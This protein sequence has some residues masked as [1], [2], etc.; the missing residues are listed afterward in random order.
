MDLIGRSKDSLLMVE[1]VIFLK[2]MVKDSEMNTTLEIENSN[3]E[4]RSWLRKTYWL[5]KEGLFKGRKSRCLGINGK[6]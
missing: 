5:D 3:L 2:Q 4:E 6:R 1:R